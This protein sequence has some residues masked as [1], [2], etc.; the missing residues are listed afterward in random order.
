MGGGV[1]EGRII[2]Q[3]DK[4]LICRECESIN[5]D[6]IVPEHYPGFMQKLKDDRVAFTLN[7]EGWLEIPARGSQ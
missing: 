1:Y 6:G 5:H 4:A 2:P 3:W 7:D